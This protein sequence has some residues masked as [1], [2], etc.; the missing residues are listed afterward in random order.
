MQ[1]PYQTLGVDRNATSDEIK[2]AYRKLASQHH[3][4]K[5]GSKERF[6]AIQA[7][8]DT[9]SD[10]QKRAMHDNP[11]QHFGGVGNQSFNFESIFD[12]FGARF[13]HPHMHRQPPQRAMMSLWITLRDA[14]IGGRKTVSLGTQQ[15]TQ[16][17]EIEIP[18]GISEGSSVQYPGIGPGGMDLIITYRIHTDPKWARQD[19]TLQT[20]HNVSIW[21][22]ILGCET[23]IRDIVGNTLT[24][25][26]PARTQ[27]GTILRLRGR[28]I[29]PKSGQPGDL[30]VQVQAQIPEDISEDLL[31]HITR[32][33]RP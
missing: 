7:A 12:I 13:Q 22:L 6:Q 1:N 27:P 5:G 8:Y 10:P 9:L 15:G 25:T 14:V 2:R 31:A 21:D 29:S 4:D 17:V 16:T 19:L 20:I 30:L 3:P 11:Q 18:A 33:H 24:L 32:I 28:G 23:N 26:V